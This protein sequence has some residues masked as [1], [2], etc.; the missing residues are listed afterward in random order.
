V[1]VSTRTGPTTPVV[2]VSIT[3]IVS[4]AAAA[5]LLLWTLIPLVFGWSSS[6][7]VSGSMRPAIGPGDV[8]VTAPVRPEQI[9]VGHVVRFQDPGNPD[10]HLLH[11]IVR[12]AEDGRLVTK[13]DANHTPD[14]NEV[15]FDAVDGIGRLRVPYV[16]LPVLWWMNRQFLRVAV[17]LVVLV[18]LCVLAPIGW[19]WADGP[20]RAVGAGGLARAATA[21]PDAAGGPAARRRQSRRAPKNTRRRR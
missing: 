13:G 20:H 6:V 15:P 14:S 18:V 10:R 9:R 1:T 2:S 5:G 21:E 4:L 17:F 12:V 11:R 19:Q 16:G 8:V 3:A 7:V